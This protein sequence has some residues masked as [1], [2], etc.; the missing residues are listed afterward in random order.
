MVVC[1]DLP[2]LDKNSLNVTLSEGRHLT[3]EG[4]IKAH[5]FA[6]DERLVVNKERFHGKFIRQIE[7]PC[8]VQTEDARKVYKSGVL[9][10][11]F[12]KSRNRNIREV[13]LDWSEE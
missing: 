12:P 4:R 10:L 3:L 5:D 11:Y 8:Q 9:E 13:K 6:R 1:C 7:L 2:G